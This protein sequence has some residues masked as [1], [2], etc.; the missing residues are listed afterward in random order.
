[1]GKTL[2]LYENLFSNCLPKTLYR[3]FLFDIRYL[4]NYIK[5]ILISETWETEQGLVEGYWSNE[6]HASAGAVQCS[7]VQCN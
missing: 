3:F 7:V 1:M 2:K 6:I 4:D 5:R